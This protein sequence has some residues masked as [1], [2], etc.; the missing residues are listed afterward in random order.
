MRRKEG[1]QEAG[2][3]PGR[4]KAGTETKGMKR[5]P[6]LGTPINAQILSLALISA[7]CDRMALP[8][9]GGKQCRK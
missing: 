5:T 3:I 7:P 2:A 6:L 8:G 4:N 1:G 9:Q